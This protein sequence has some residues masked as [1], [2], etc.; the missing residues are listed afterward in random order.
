MADLVRQS[1]PARGATVDSDPTMPP[2]QSLANAGNKRKPLFLHEFGR[3]VC[4]VHRSSREGWKLCMFVEKS[5][6]QQHQHNN[7]QNKTKKRETPNPN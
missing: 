7:P 1:E 4:G 6:A 5:K 3:H 2:E